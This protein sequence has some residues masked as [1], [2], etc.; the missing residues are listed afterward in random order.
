MSTPVPRIQHVDLEAELR[1][2]N[3]RVSELQAQL[4]EKSAEVD[5]L[6]EVT[7]GVAAARDTESMLQFIAEMAVRVTHTDSSSIYVFDETKKN[8]VLKAVHEAPHGLVGRLSLKIGEGITGWVARAL[9]PVALE[10]DAFKDRRFKS[11]P[12]L[13]DQQCH[14]F[15]SVPMSA[16]NEIIG[17]LNVKTQDPHHYPPRAVRLLQAVASQAAAALQGMR[18]QES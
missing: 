3:L 9:H 1:N 2:A 4:D 12:D 16:Q 15:L 7:A 11:L 17:V 13:R 10:R 8:L 5:L 14:S 6:H 18:L